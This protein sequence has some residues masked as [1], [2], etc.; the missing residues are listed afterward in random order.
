MLSTVQVWRL[1]G[2]TMQLSVPS[3]YNSLWNISRQKAHS[4]KYEPNVGVQKKS[5]AR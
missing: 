4:E 3:E 1:I 2:M 5:W